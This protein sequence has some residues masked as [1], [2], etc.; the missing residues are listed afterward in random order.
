MAPKAIVWT[1]SLLAATL[2]VG[3]PAAFAQ[4]ESPHPEPAAPPTP[5]ALVPAPESPTPDPAPLRTPPPATWSEA[6]SGPNPPA[7]EPPAAAEPEP[8]PAPEIP[9]EPAQP[10][11][12]AQANV[13]PPLPMSSPSVPPN[14]RRPREDSTNPLRE[15]VLTLDQSMTTQSASIG[16]TPQ[17]YVPL[18]E[19]WLSFRPRYHFDEHWSVRGRFDY[20]KELTNAEQTTYAQEDV[21]GD[22]WT[23]GV[24]ETK[25]DSLWPLTR[26]EIGVRAIWPTSK[27]SQGNGTYVTLGPRAVLEHRFMIHG[28]DAP[29]LNLV[30][31]RA[32]VVYLHDFSAATTPN[33]YG[34][35]GYVRQNVEDQSF[36]SDAISGQ[37]LP[38]H[39]IDA[40]ISAQLNITPRLYL[41]STFVVLAQWHYAPT[42]GAN[43][44]ISGGAVAVSPAINDNQFTEFTWWT[45]EVSYDLVDEIT[46]SLGYYD[47]ANAVAPDG[48][49]RSVF[50]S[51]NIWWSPSA[52]F[53]FDITANLDSIFD[54]ARGHVYTHVNDETARESRVNAHIH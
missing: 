20:T 40:S 31:A 41:G 6:P 7:A 4:G 2:F 51:E 11:T 26:V 44:P 21:F 37:T 27:I 17:S 53:F 15:S 49:G 46:L 10:E 39:E 47:L 14:R 19:L 54:D 43:I 28:M 25:L 50:G 36:V 29:W 9:A 3:A 33:D 13:S 16:D 34:N 35:F 48:Q 38:E 5:E 12:P 18:Y 45:A 24:Y 42:S 22:V 30:F 8:A 23:D 52:R 1:G 32:G